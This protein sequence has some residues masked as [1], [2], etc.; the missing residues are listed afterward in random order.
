MRH[1]LDTPGD[2]VLGGD[3][4]CVL[5]CTYRVGGV[6]GKDSS[7][8]TLRGVLRDNDLVDVTSRFPGFM[9][10]YTRWQGGSHARLDRLYVSSGLLAG[11]ASYSFKMV[12]FSDHV[13]V[14]TKPR[15]DVATKRRVRGSWKMNITILDSQEFSARV[16]QRLENFGRVVDAC[17]WE[18][19]K[20]VL[21][22]LA[23][24][25]SQ[26]KATEARQESEVRRAIKKLSGNKAPRPDGIGAEFYKTYVDLLCPILVEV[27][28]DIFQR[29]LLPPS[30]RASLTVLIP[31]KAGNSSDPAVTDYRP[32]SL[33]CGD[34]KIFAKSLARRL[35]L[36][37]RCVVG[38]HQAY[39]LRG[40]SIA[41]NLHA[42]R[43]VR[44]ASGEGH[45]PLAVLQLDMSQAFDRV[46]HEFL[47]AVLKKCEVGDGMLDWVG[48]CYRDISTRLLVNGDKGRSI[49]I[50]RSVRQGCPL[51]PILFAL[52][53]EPLWRSIIR[54]ATMQGLQMG[55][56]QVKPLAYA[57]DVALMCTF[58]AQV[59]AALQHVAVL[60]QASGAA[61][62]RQKFI[63]AWLGDW[64]TTPKIFADIEWRTTVDSYLG[65]PIEER[66]PTVE[67][68]R[69][70][71]NAIQAKLP[72]GSAG[73]Y[74]S[75]IEQ[76]AASVEFFLVL[77]SW[78]YLL[79]ASRK[80]LYWDTLAIVLPVPLYRMEPVPLCGAELFKRVRRFPVPASTKDF[81]VPLHLEVL[82]VKVW[83][84]ARM[85]FRP[86]VYELRP[87]WR[88]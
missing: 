77:F 61:V 78:G 68:W 18:A 50:G 34:N 54:D 47:R 25:F 31:K 20:E 85:C 82:P 86:L 55:D 58:K 63:G 16:Q 26:T 87:V 38:D 7:A 22:E 1:M 17:T 33:L 9:L 67:K 62:N 52:Q 41:R 44:E 81:F 53:L 15:S 2:I 84:D 57:D 23:E 56:Q 64:A 43:I 14:T 3:F 40:R 6:A 46:S 13:L 83:L 10:R 70:K 60:S 37:L 19:F 88:E 72:R 65:A 42:M 29:K 66:G 69:L 39:G 49:P 80:T 5:S 24:A 48:L 21:R 35:D 30:M 51:S 79:A 27:Y 75:L 32:I 45:Q 59:E 76:I 73:G 8:T 71:T 4:N 74:R 36:G 28:Q 11:A 12:P